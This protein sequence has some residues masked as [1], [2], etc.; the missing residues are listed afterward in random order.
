[1]SA[2]AFFRKIFMLDLLKGMSITQKFFL[3]PKVT[4]QYPKERWKPPERFRGMLRLEKNLCTACDLCAK[5]CPESI[6]SI[7]GEKGADKKKRPVTFTID[8]KRC[9][10]CG[11]CA[12]V[13]PTEALTVSKDYELSMF[14][15]EDVFLDMEKLSKG[16]DITPYKK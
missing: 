4:M 10:F 15:L 6:I 14:K 13:C 9:T 11:F 5:E 1:M 7:T 8:L 2:A 12:E 16:V 3:A